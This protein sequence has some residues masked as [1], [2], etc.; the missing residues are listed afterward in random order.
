MQKFEPESAEISASS[1]SALI[2]KYLRNTCL[3]QSAVPSVAYVYT[4][5][6]DIIQRFEHSVACLSHCNTKK[7]DRE[8]VKCRLYWLQGGKI[9]RGCS[10][11]LPA[12]WLYI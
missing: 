5:L 6:F 11:R 9:V 12:Q 2:E 8:Y 7:V 1:N 4:I 3:G 10:S